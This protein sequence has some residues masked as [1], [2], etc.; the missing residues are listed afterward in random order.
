MAKQLARNTHVIDPDSGEVTRYFAGDTVPAKHAK[1]ITSEAAWG[2]NEPEVLA[3]DAANND[4]VDEFESMSYKALL[5][6][7]RE[8]NLQF[9]KNP[10]K[11]DVLAALRGETNEGGDTGGNDD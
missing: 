6:V 10:S 3:N 11:E 9:D 5:N 8:R 2:T 1:L 4:D 7:A